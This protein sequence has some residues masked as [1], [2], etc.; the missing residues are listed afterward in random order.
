MNYIVLCHDG[1]E[2]VEMLTPVDILRRAGNSVVIV[3]MTGN[4]VINGSHGIKI[5]ADA[6]FEEI[7]TE[8][9]DTVILPG[10][11]P[12]AHTL[13]DDARVTDTVKA[14]DKAGKTVAA[15][16]A[17]PC[18]LE[19]AGLLV[20]RAATSYPGAI[21]AEKCRYLEIP[22]V[23]AVNVITSRGVGTAI[24]FALAIL[25]HDGQAEAAEKIAKGIMYA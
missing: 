8:D 11:L 6:L 20:N 9:F 18:V 23:V 22:V 16:C 2:E 15:I 7:K 5:T 12:N 14:F 17:A 24:E 13:R 4:K 21:D 10:G 1:F 25:R 19:R 3:S